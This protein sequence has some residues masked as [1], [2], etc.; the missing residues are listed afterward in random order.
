MFQDPGEQ[1]VGEEEGDWERRRDGV[2]A[3][4]NWVGRSIEL[5]TCFGCRFGDAWK[6]HGVFP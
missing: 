4:Q 2:S 6:L 1:W 5:H 3:V